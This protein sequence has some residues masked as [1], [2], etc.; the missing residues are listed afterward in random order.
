MALTT[1]IQC[2]SNE[3]FDLYAVLLKGQITC[4]TDEQLLLLDYNIDGLAVS[5]IV[6]SPTDPSS[7]YTAG[8]G[9]VTFS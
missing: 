4:S 3:L 8:T 1:S 7:P 5:N 9:T 2:Y 6:T